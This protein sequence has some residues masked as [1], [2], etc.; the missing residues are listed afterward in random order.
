MSQE[1]T[2]IVLIDIPAAIAANQLEGNIYLIDN[3]RTEGS[4]GEGTGQLVTAVNGSYWANG[5]QADEALLNW[6][7]QGIGNLPLSLPRSFHMHKPRTEQLDHV[8][9]SVNKDSDTNKV[10]MDVRKKIGHAAKVRDA[11]GGLQETGMR[12]LNVLGEPVDEG[13]SS[14][15]ELN[16]LTPQLDAISG[17]AVDKGILY[18]A[19]YG[20]PI[21]IKDGWYW[22]ATADTAKTGEYGYTMHFTL[23]KLA[24][25]KH[26][27]VWEPVRMSYDSKIRVTTQ[28]KLNG[29]TGAGMGILPIN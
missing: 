13:E 14:V 1:I 5:G 15:S 21:S 25:E 6:L 20:T 17:E 22:S 23:F 26:R 18:P 8:F 4:K 28:P 9:R 11:R 19:Q 3:L 27:P 12:V 24:Y 10:M 29:F 2:I 16:H 7:P